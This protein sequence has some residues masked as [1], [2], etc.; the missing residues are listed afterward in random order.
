MMED[1]G[2]GDHELEGVGVDGEVDV[3]AVGPWSSGEEADAA[4]A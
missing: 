3:A 1:G 2:D 4:G